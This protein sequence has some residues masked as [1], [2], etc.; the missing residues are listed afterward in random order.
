MNT[1]LMNRCDELRQKPFRIG[2]PV[3]PNY[4][5]KHK[6]ITDV[7]A[8]FDL[9]HE[10]LGLHMAI[11]GISGSG[12]S[13]FLEG[14]C[15][16][17]IDTCQGGI[18]IDPPGD[19]G[20]LVLEYVALLAK[21]YGDEAILPRFH[22]LKP[23]PDQ[24]FSFDP[25]RIDED[26]RNEFAFAAAR[27]TAVKKL[28]RVMLRS[29]AQVDEEK[30]RRLK[31]ML[32][33]VITL[34]AT[35]LPDG[36]RLSLAEFPALVNPTHKLHKQVID[37]YRGHLPEMVQLD[38]DFLELLRKR[39]QDINGQMEST[40]N[41]GADF[42]SILSRAIFGLQAPSIDF[43]RIIREGHFVVLTLAEIK[44]Q[45]SEA[46]SAIADFVIN[47]IRNT[48]AETPVAERRP[49]WMCIDEA[50]RHVADDLGQF[51]D[52]ARKWRL[53]V[54]L[55]AQHLSNF[56]K[57]D[58]IDLID[59]LMG[60]CKTF[61]SF[62]QRSLFDVKTLGEFFGKPNLI[63]QEREQVMDRP[64]KPNDEIITL[65]DHGESTSASVTNSN[66]ISIGKSKSKGRAHT[67]STSNGWSSFNAS[68]ES[69]STSTHESTS[70]SHGTNTGM[71]HHDSASDSMS[72]I[73]VDGHV[74][75]LPGHMTGSGLSSF[76]GRSESS[77]SSHGSSE[78]HSTSTAQ[79][80]AQSSS[81]G[82]AKS[83]SYSSSESFIE[84]VT[85][86]FKTGHSWA[87]QNQPAEP[88]LLG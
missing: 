19:T 48:C 50:G 2:N 45:S 65:T 25:L 7:D 21:K 67:K 66:G 41:R 32:E 88:G 40:V 17:H 30:M 85:R 23:S 57:G 42:F 62:Q 3:Q 1:W 20:E 84:S 76:D 81:R 60:N 37:T 72:P 34:I 39:P 36:T 56:Q 29:E 71:G 64:Y 46:S 28:I 16:Y 33:A 87:L 82:R 26:P 51:L 73:M 59:Q 75:H 5:T 53:S 24:L 12:K 49:F 77:G 14:L 43:R 83:L 63:L 68:S 79:G 35:P 86:R 52:E 13:K 31:R 38:F 44:H 18:L 15:R 6:L 11:L 70:E 55:C 22:Y 4:L 80:N 27:E 47:D 9:Q 69:E 8:E 61:V 10:Q 58:N 54:C 74:L 78:G